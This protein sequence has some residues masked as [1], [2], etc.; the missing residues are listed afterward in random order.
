MS[1]TPE[2]VEQLLNSEDFGD[3]LRAVNQLRQLEPA[4]AYNLIQ[5]AIG[6][7]NIRVRYA[8]VSQM[9]TLGTQ[10]RSNALDVLLDSL[11]NDPEPDV[12]AAAADA[13]GALKL[14]EALEDL[15]QL[16]NNTSEWLIQLSIVAALGEMGDP[17][18]FPILEKALNSEHE[19]IQT[20]AIGA[21]GELG[22]K[23]ALPLLLPYVSNADWQV[24]YRVAQALVRLGGEQAEAALKIL[25]KDE[26]EQVALEAK[27]A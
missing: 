6:D 18:A 12:K 20:M 10:N 4:I 13:L 22:D 3:R 17:K 23:R 5:S 8:A 16:Y 26:V 9:S 15:E 11:R 25:A 2:S 24:R 19:L 7:K 14:T 1:I 21:L 27:G